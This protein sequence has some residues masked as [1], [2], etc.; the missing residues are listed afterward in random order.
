ML[1]T[2][3]P[4]R[5]EAILSSDNTFMP[6]N[7][8]LKE[9]ISQMLL[10]GFKGITLKPDD[11]IVR[12][13]L[14]QHIG[15]VILFDYDYQ[16]KIPDRN[17]QSPEQLRALT[18]QLQTYA[19]QAAAVKQN[20]LFPLFIGIDYEGGKVNRLKEVYGFPPAPSAAE[21][22]KGSPGAAQQ[23]AEIMA[24]TLKKAGINLNFA[25]VLDVNVNPD[26]PAIVKLDRSFSTDPQKVTNYAAIFA[27]AYRDHGIL[28]A[29]KHFP[30]HGSSTQ[31]TH[32]TFVDVTDTWKEEELVPYQSLFKNPDT[33]SIV[34][35]A[36]V[37]NRK[38]DDCP[39]SISTPII[40]E[41]LR[42]TLHFKGAV[43]TDD[44]QMKGITDRYGLALAVKMAVNAGAD[45]LI[46]GNQLV[47]TPQD[48][49]QVV[50]I[51]YDAV[52]AGEI[53]ESRIDE[54]FGRIS[55]LKIF[56]SAA[57]HH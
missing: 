35:T 55:A 14:S 24:V 2:A 10:I 27:K 19:K 25:P 12:S 22:G 4:T 41:L 49:E 57:T 23:Q 21:I 32:H 11:A 16:S 45:L 54:A 29:Y 38:Y 46:F 52:Q 43:V 15:G 17:I 53:K 37:V 47:T 31:D 50:N 42:N 3:S 56:L 36:H 7:P 44:M 34:M 13:I 6:A 51:I 26:N 30:G 9:K 1:S 33:C 18:Q 8:T 20:D 40:T 28:C 39:A 48:P 5:G